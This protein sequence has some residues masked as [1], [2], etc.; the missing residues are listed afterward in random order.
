[1]INPLEIILDK[2]NC[3]G[4]QQTVS[5]KRRKPM[6][7]TQNL[8][9]MQVRS[10]P[11]CKLQI[12]TARPMRRRD[13]IRNDTAEAASPRRGDA[14]HFIPNSIPCFAINLTK[15]MPLKDEKPRF[16]VVWASS[17]WFPGVVMFV[18]FCERKPLRVGRYAVHFIPRS[19]FWGSNFKLNTH[20]PGS[21]LF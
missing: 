5:L 2:P 14:P 16:A 3:K 4:C 12:K 20:C 1:M 21:H 11:P 7:R 18:H 9:Q 6:K 13:G 17:V 8:Q 15:G 19:I 10:T